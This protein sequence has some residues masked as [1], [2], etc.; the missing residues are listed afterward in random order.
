MYFWRSQGAALFS[1]GRALGFPKR[2]EVMDQSAPRRGGR[3]RQGILTVG[4]RSMSHIS[5]F[6]F[7][8]FPTAARVMCCVGVAVFD[9]VCLYVLVLFFLFAIIEAVKV[10]YQLS[11]D[12]KEPSLLNYSVVPH[13][14]PFLRSLACLFCILKR[15]LRTCVKE[16][17]STVHPLVIRS[18]NRVST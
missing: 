4:L 6:L 12:A 17:P 16:E 13:A 11:K 1:R 14:L 3:R 9:C 18:P 10:C 8:F 2:C 5:F 7:Y 15:T